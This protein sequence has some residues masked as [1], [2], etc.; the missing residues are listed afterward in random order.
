MLPTDQ[1]LDTDDP[2]EVEVD[3][4]LE[5]QDELV[6]LDRAFELLAAVQALDRLDVHVVGEEHAAVRAGGLGRVHRQVGVAQQIRS[7]RGGRDPDRRAQVQAL[8]FEHHGGGQHG[9]DPVH[10]G[11]QV[12]HLDRQDRE[13]VAAQARDGVARAQRVAQP[14]AGDLQ[15]PVTGGVAERV[16]D[17]LEVV[18]VEERDHRGLT[19]GQRL[20]DAALE[21]RAVRETRE[22]VLEREPAQLGIARAAAAGAV[23]QAEQRG[24]ADDEQRHDGDGPEPRQ[25]IAARGDD[26]VALGGHPQAPAQLVAG[27][28]DETVDRRRALEVARPQQRELVLVRG[29]PPLEGRQGGLGPEPAVVAQAP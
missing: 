11:V 27:G 16:V 18:E 8:A 25:T 22:R 23:E 1:R 13:L 10:E 9:E 21:Q 29:A 6:V 3:D 17:P 24:Q 4:R 7:G 14:L 20:G 19:A 2:V 12:G 26:A 15:Q 28:I 5:V